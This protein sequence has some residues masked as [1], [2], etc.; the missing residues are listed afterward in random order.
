METKAGKN[1]KLASEFFNLHAGT[2]P[3]GRVP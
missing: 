1:W 2:K 3:E